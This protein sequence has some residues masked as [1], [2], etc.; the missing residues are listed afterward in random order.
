MGYQII[1]QDPDD[2]YAIFSSYT[3]TIVVWDA[4]VE[5][6]V[7]WFVEQEAA[8]VRERVTAIAGNVAAGEPRK[9]YFQ[10]AKSWE[11]VQRMDREHDGAFSTGLGVEEP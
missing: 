7:E 10:F 3:D 8:R 4:S 2:L 9:V 6:V 5:E 11:D 1:R